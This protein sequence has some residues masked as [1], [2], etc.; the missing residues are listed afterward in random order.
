MKDHFLPSAEIFLHQQFRYFEI[1][2]R[3][4]RY[5]NVWHGFVPMQ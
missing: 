1:S 5:V 3:F 4:T 2:V